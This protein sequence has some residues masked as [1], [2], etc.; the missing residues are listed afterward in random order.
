VNGLIIDARSAPRFIQEEAYRKG[1]I[2]Y[3]PDDKAGG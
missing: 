3:I 2:P 1:L